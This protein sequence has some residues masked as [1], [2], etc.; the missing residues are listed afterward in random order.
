[1]NLGPEAVGTKVEGQFSADE[2]LPLTMLDEITEIRIH[3]PQVIEQEARRRKRRARLTRDGKLVLAALDHPARGVT[4]VGPQELAIA[5]RNQ[6]LA[7]TRWVLEDPDLDGVL[8]TSDELEELL[9][10]SRL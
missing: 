3:R 1:M 2:V 9:I 4:R 7:R 6:L 8:V 5:D 10:L